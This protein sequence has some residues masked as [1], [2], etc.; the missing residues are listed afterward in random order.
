[1]TSIQANPDSRM[2][3]AQLLSRVIEN[4]VSCHVPT[5]QIGTA[6]DYRMLDQSVLIP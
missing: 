1:M 2:E 3:C 4:L 6:L 5:V